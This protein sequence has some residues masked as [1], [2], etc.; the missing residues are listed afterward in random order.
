MNDHPTQSST[1]KREL[2]PAA[3]TITSRL[4][5]AFAVASCMALSVQAQTPVR[6]ARTNDS[7]ATNARLQF[8]LLVGQSNMAGRGTVEVE[9]STP[10]A[11]VWMLTQSGAWAPAVEPLHFDKPKVAGV[12]PGRAFGVAVAQAWKGTEIGMVPAAVGGSSIRAW[13]TGA[14]DS[15]TKTH[16]YDDAIARARVAMQR[17]SLAG[18][19]WLQGE[20]D[21]NA[22]NAGDYEQRLFAVI[23]NLRRDLQAPE[24]P[25]LI[26]QM[27]NF[28]EKPWNAY[29]ARVDSA[30]RNVAATTPHSAFILTEG[31]RHRGDTVHYDAPSAREIGRRYAK[32]FLL[33]VKTP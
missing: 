19:L 26:G 30:H 16:P 17:G 23:A 22:R 24:V 13:E 20:S 32:H 15:A 6:A 29:R 21:G 25:F 18:I 12:G 4:T 3:I 7:L 11:H 8:F 10:V 33:M 31:L 14:A 2:W 1:M 27:G 28:P 5:T 9:D